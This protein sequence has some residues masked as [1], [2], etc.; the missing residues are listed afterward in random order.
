MV[1]IMNT[2]TI[3]PIIVRI[4]AE[5]WIVFDLFLGSK[6]MPHDEY[7]VYCNRNTEEPD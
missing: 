5:G 2:T 7:L 6:K 3:L 4:T 1:V